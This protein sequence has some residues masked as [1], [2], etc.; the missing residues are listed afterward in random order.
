[1]AE[2]RSDGSVLVEEPTVAQFLAVIANG[3]V[4]GAI[5][6]SSGSG[7]GAGVGEVNGGVPQ[8][9]LLAVLYRGLPGDYQ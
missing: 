6:A 2:V 7:W 9:L 1:M 5:V 8:G 4:F 3:F